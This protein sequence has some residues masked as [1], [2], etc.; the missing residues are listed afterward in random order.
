M[1]KIIRKV[2][3]YLAI[4]LG[5]FIFIMCI[6]GAILVFQNE[7]KQIQNPDFYSLSKSSIEGKTVL[8]LQE[9][10]PIINTQLED[11]SVKEV[12]I[13]NEPEKTYRISLSEGFREVAFINPYSGEVIG[14]E[15]PNNSIFMKVM[16]LHRW[17]MDSTRTW[18]KAI[19]G[20]STVAFI[21]ILITGFFY[22]KKKYKSNYKIVTNKGRKRLF[23]DLHNALGNYTFILLLILALTGLMWSFTPYRNAVFYIFGHRTTAESQVHGRGGKGG[24][25]GD[26]EKK[27]V[28]YAIWDAALENFKPLASS[29]DFIKIGEQ[30]ITAHPKNTYRP[31]VTDEYGYNPKTGQMTSTT[32]YESKPIGTRVM[33]WAYSLHVGDYWGI[34]SKIITCLASLVGASLPITGYY[35]WAKKLKRKKMKRA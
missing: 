29:Y 22:F 3:T 21:F 30:S 8:S 11:N 14:K 5:L 9:L 27:Q 31:R 10:I 33:M 35:L 7:I 4:P 12:T 19:T 6:T 25:K 16:S 20:W 2:H 24:E 23:F 32:L 28:N 1:R 34:W 13:Y 18:G 15:V 17:L 26:K